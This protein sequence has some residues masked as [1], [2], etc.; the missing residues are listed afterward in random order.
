MQDIYKLWN[1]WSVYKVISNDHNHFDV[2]GYF[3]LYINVNGHIFILVL[4]KYFM[5]LLPMCRIVN[6]S[7]TMEGLQKF[8]IEINISVQKLINRNRTL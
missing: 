8:Q 3:N 5:L 7:N 2:I 1:T 4:T 6:N